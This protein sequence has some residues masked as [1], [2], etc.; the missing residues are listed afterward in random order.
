M[1]PGRNFSPRAFG[2][3]AAEKIAHAATRRARL[4]VGVWL[5]LVVLLSGLGHELKNELSIHPVLV[6]GSSSKRAHEIAL[7]EF[8][9]D[10]PI[11]VLLRGPQQDVERQGRLLAARIGETPPMLAVS[12]WDSSG[13]VVDG[14]NPRPGVAAV[15][16]RTASRSGDEVSDLLPP[17]QRQINRTVSAPVHTSLAGL[18]VII[19]SIREAN[20]HAA[21]LGELIAVPVLLLVLLLAFRSFLAALTPLLVGGAVVVATQGLLSLLLH[22]VEL[23]LIVLGVSAMMGLALG[24]DYSLLVVSRFREEREHSDLPEAMQMTI[25]ATGRAILPAGSALLLAMII[26]PVVLPGLLIRSVAIGVGVA[27]VLSMVSALCVVPALL[28]VFGRHLDRWGLPTRRN[29]QIAPLRWSRAIVKRPAAVI[30][31]VCGLLLLAGLAFNLQS[32]VATAGLLPAGDT[33]RIQQEEVEGALGPGWVAP[34]EVVINGRD[35]PITSPARLR[36]IAGFQRQAEADPGVASVAGL[37]Q[38]QRSTSKLGGIEAELADQERGLDRLNRGINRIGAG[39]T[40]NTEGLFSA[41][42]GSQKLEAGA[43]SARAGAGALTSGLK[44]TSA[45]SGRLSTGLGRADA[46]SGKLAQG[47]AEASSGASRIAQG[48]SSSKEKTGEIQGNARLFENAMGTGK[49]DLEQLHAPLHDTETQLALA[50]QAL[51]RMTSGKGDP[52]YAAALAAVE[53]ASKKLTGSDPGSGEP[54]DPGY[55]GV[56]AG[57]GEAEGQFEVGEYLSTRMAK[58][59]RQAEK[60]LGKLADASAR[61]DHGLRRLSAASQQ[62]SSGVSAL[63]RGSEALSPA[64]R[65]L[66]QGAESLTAGLGLLD[67]GSGQL[68]AGLQEGAEKS[69]ALPRALR[70]IGSGL[71]GQ[72]GESHLNQLQQRA[73]GLFRSSYFVLAALDGTPPARRTQLET[74][75]NI[76]RGG[77]DARVLVVPKDDPSSDAA[78]DTAERLEGDAKKLE[79]KTGA[80]VVVGGIGPADAAINNEI[81]GQTPLMRLVLALIGLLVLIP[82]LRSLIVPIFAVLINLVTV[83]ASF[84]VLSLLFNGSFFGGPGYVDATVIPGTIMVIFGLAIDYE[85]FVFARIRE[86]YLRTGSTR[87][88]VELGLDRTAPVVTGAAVIMMT[89]FLAFSASGFISIRNFGIAQAVAVFIDAFVV[90]LVIVPALMLWLGDRCWWMPRWLSRFRTPTERSS[91][92]PG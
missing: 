73:P 79:K 31:L 61:L 53:E 6:N 24:V 54:T 32:G 71:E 70:R 39:A 68:T 52:E 82:L 27:T 21:S 80:E 77:T 72:R 76:D 7:H 8:G 65:R 2:R 91:V 4:V 18:P 15:L 57:V 55:E 81:R 60:G 43:S 46:G 5:L 41:A 28:T 13:A 64:L 67:Q 38:I 74:L 34:M 26:A 40:R 36:A 92:L 75:I 66:S 51:L 49:G 62:V 42:K 20:S 85:V 44:K 11:V 45:G 83:S 10:Y 69:R 48:L 16:V 59:G 25:T 86:E 14:L 17:L 87:K 84:G 1:S 89:V 78:R 50:R 63:S 12:P 56:A 58:N 37:R 47:T 3:A 35:K 29:R 9:N 33:G 19:N 88:A 90:R 23:D 30:A 22:L